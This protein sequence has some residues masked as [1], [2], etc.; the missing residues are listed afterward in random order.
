V[1]HPNEPDGWDCLGIVHEAR[2]ENPQ[3]ADCYRKMRHIVR[4]RPDDDEPKYE[5]E[6]ADDRQ[7]GST[8]RRLKTITTIQLLEGRN[9]PTLT[10]RAQVA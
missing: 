6:F 7:S 2:G 3:A 10:K 1:R 4:Q 9:A 8:D 5:T